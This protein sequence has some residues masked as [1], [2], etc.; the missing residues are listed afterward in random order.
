MGWTPEIGV[1]CRTHCSKIKTIKKYTYDMGT[2]HLDRAN[3]D[4]SHRHRGW[5]R[6]RAKN[7]TNLLSPWYSLCV[8]PNVVSH[9]KPLLAPLRTSLTG[10]FPRRGVGLCPLGCVLVWLGCLV[11]AARLVVAGYVPMCLAVL[12][13]WPRLFVLGCL[14]FGGL[15][16]PTHPGGISRII[17]LYFGSGG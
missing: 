12:L 8:S 4:P 10:M 15:W 5:V 6:L 16:G 13:G 3:R 11:G 1:I 9:T 2:L 17:I 14:R 7:K